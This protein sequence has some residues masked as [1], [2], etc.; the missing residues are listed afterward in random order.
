M[1]RFEQPTNNVLAKRSIMRKGFI[2]H[3]KANVITPIIIHVQ[4]A[5]L[6]LFASR[7]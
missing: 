5:H 2:K 4:A 7:K 3:A 6:K 1:C